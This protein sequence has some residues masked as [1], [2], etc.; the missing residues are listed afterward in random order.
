MYPTRATLPLAVTAL[1]VSVLAGCSSSDGPEERPLSISTS[2]DGTAPDVRTSTA[3]EDTEDILAAG[4]ARTQAMID[5]DVARLDQ[6][7]AD[8]F[9]AMHTNGYEQPKAEWLKQVASGDM[10]YHEVQEESVSVELDS[11]TAVLTSRNLVTATI[12]GADGTWPLESTTQYAR[13][14][15]VWTATSSRSVTY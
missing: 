14:D 7:L 5:R 13:I 9:V 11:D 12:N 10:S 15:G 4:R 2:P 6:L 3:T 1:A 8:D